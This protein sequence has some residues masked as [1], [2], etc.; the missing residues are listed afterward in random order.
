MG[1]NTQ[2]TIT[3][4][5]TGASVGDQDEDQ[6]SMDRVSGGIIHQALRPDSLRT[7]K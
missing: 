1:K 6:W 7:F 3:I 2:K 4:P 5:T